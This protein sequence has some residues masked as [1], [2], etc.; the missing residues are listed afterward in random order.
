MDG[1][2]EKAKLSICRATSILRVE[3]E[4]RVDPATRDTSSGELAAWQMNRVRWG[5]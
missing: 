5:L 2:V 1:D 3:L 4:R